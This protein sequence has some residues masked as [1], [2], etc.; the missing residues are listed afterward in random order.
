MERKE[1]DKGTN[2]RKRKEGM[3]GNGNG[4]GGKE[5]EKDVKEKKGISKVKQN[6]NEN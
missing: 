1:A 5:V 3:K 4:R 6:R 2:Y